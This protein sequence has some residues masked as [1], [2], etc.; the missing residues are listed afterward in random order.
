M[1]QVTRKA[2]GVLR[3]LFRVSYKLPSYNHQRL[4]I[5]RTRERTCVRI[6][7]L[8]GRTNTMSQSDCF[9]FAL[10]VVPILKT[11]DLRSHLILLVCAGHGPKWSTLSLQERQNAITEAELYLDFLEHQLSHLQ[12]MKESNLLVE[13][14]DENQIR[15]ARRKRIEERRRARLAAQQQQQQ[16][17]EQQTEQPSMPVQHS[18][19]SK[20]EDTNR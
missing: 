14:V 16:Q 10:P 6:F 20:S 19:T 7:P 5:F 1:D 12:A 8:P 13:G 9:A 17:Q 18:H 11:H 2:V 15:E 4:A 3:Q